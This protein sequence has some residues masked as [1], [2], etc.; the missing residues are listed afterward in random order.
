MAIVQ[1]FVIDQG[2]TFVARVNVYTSEKLNFDLTDYTAQS[3]IRKTPTS[4]VIAE[5]EC[6]IPSPKTNGQI[7]LNLTDE[8]TLTIASGR[9]MYDVV[10]TSVAGEKYRAVEGIITVKPLITR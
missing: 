9:Y 1:N 5:F 10:I 2:S 8:Q 7:I 6:T 4:T 3:Q